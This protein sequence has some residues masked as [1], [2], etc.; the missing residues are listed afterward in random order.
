MKDTGNSIPRCARDGLDTISLFGMTINNITLATV[1]EAVTRQIEAREP[2][3]II[4]PNVD[5]V[6]TFQEDAEFREAYYHS[7]LVLADGMPVL[8]SSKLVGKPLKEKISGSD[9]VYWL[10]EYAARRGYSVFFFGATEGTAQRAGEVLQ[11]KYPGLKVAGA[12]SPPMGFDKDPE[13][14]AESIQIVRDADPDICYVALGAPKQDLWSYR[15]HRE[16]G[17][18]VHIGVG[19][20]LNFVTGDVKRAPRWMQR[21]GLEWVWRL[22]QEP[23]RLLKRYL[24]R[25]MQLLPLLWRE[26]WSSRRGKA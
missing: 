8:W 23:R 25:D 4:T 9:L 26:F 20:S 17:V 22:F 11:E 10:S 1:F 16:T 18:P 21:N 15:H 2:G 5:H 6:V 12:Y 14:L 24:V 19:I 3:Y 13:L 7:F